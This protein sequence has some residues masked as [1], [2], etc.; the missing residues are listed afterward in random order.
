MAISI[1]LLT[2]VRESMFVHLTSTP[3]ALRAFGHTSS[4]LSSLPITWYPRTICRGILTSRFI[5]GILARRVL[6]SV[7]LICSK[8]QQSPL[9]TLTYWLFQVL[10]A[11]NISVSIGQC[12]TIFGKALIVPKPREVFLIEKLQSLRIYTPPS[13]IIFRLLLIFVIKGIKL[14]LKFF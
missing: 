9:I 11:L 4:V 13:I 8:G 5:V 3:T 1:S 6:H 12:T 14:V 10:S 7:L 2:I